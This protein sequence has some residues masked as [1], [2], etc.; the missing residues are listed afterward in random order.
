MAIIKTTII[1]GELLK[2]YSII[3]LNFDIETKLYPFIVTAQNDIRKMLGDELFGELISQIEDKTITDGNK[4][5]LVEIASPL[6]SLVCW[7]AY[8][9]LWA[10]VS[11]KGVTKE[12]SENSTSLTKNELN[13]TRTDIKAL[14]D[15]QMKD[16][17]EYLV[18][19]QDKYPL[20]DCNKS[21]KPRVGDFIYLGY[22]E[23]KSKCK[24]CNCAD[25]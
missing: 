9:H 22:S 17:E 21:K 1:S 25:K 5:L 7:Y 24:P 16:L 12:Q 6:S 10:S 15:K 23:K 8:P 14:A 18:R 19:C 3:P 2:T 4:A 20:Y 11:Q 13:Y